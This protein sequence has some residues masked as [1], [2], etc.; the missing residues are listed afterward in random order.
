MPSEQLGMTRQASFE[1]AEGADCGNALR[2]HQWVSIISSWTGGRRI[3]MLAIQV[4][5]LWMD[6]EAV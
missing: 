4:H 5:P 3:A 1:F 6:P 2:P